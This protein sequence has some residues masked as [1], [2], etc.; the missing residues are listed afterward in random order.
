MT[1]GFLLISLLFRWYVCDDEAMCLVNRLGYTCLRLGNKHAEQLQSIGARLP[2]AVV[3]NILSVAPLKR[4]SFCCN[5]GKSLTAPT[6]G[7]REAIASYATKVSAFSINRN[8]KKPLKN[9]KN[10][11]KRTVKRSRTLRSIAI[12]I[13]KNLVVNRTNYNQLTIDTLVELLEAI[14]IGLKESSAE[15]CLVIELI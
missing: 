4:M 15:Y 3:G 10:W 1:K 5:E 13:E 11:V 12:S 9:L 14:I 8:P 2:F 7:T 6:K